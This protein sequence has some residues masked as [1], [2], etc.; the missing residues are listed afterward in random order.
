MTHESLIAGFRA[1]ISAVDAATAAASTQR[2]NQLA[3]PP[4]SLGCVEPLG[5]QLSQIAGS[6]PPPIP[7]Q[8]HVIVAAGDHGVHRQGVSDWPQQVTRSMVE[9][10]RAGRATINA[11][12]ASAQTTV[13]LLDIG[14]VSTEPPNATH[15]LSNTEIERPADGTLFAQARIGSGTEDIA[16]RGAMSAGACTLAIDIGARLTTQLINSGADLIAL[17][18]LGI[19]NTTASACLIATMTG[20]EP[21]TV[22][23]NGANVDDSRLQRKIAVVA[24]AL[25]R[26][27]DDSAPLA[28]LASLGG[29]EHAALVG[30][31]LEAAAR[32]IPIVLD[33]VT[34]NAAAL[35]AVALVPPVAGYLIAGHRS[36]EPGAHAALKHLDL[37]PLLDHGMRLGEGTGATLAIP[38]IVAAARVLNQV[39]TIEEVT[40]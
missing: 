22:T 23:G 28:T 14:T 38:T 39:A 2:W 9:T 37:N 25:Q 15:W 12:A 34:T 29:F 3:K 17:G 16:N 10:V 32:R 4:G 30:V 33:G 5:D 1:R 18:D 40:A 11:I 19:A 6:C 27:G 7:Q 36:V 26:H 13:V 8:P 20:S 21:A 24:A 35:V 31:I